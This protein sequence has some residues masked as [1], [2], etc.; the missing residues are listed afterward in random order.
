MS[1]LNTILAWAEAL[2]WPKFALRCISSSSLRFLEFSD[3]FFLCLCCALI[4]FRSSE[5]SIV[6]QSA[7]RTTVIAICRPSDSS[8]ALAYGPV[9]VEN[10]ELQMS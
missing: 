2:L 10:E 6:P 1:T 3:S 4:A 8:Y 5:K 9:A 7:P